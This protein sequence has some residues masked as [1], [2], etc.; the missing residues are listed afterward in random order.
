MLI[1]Y[2][3]CMGRRMRLVDIGWQDY[4]MGEPSDGF[5]FFSPPAMAR[6]IE[7]VGTLPA[8]GSLDK[9]GGRARL[10]SS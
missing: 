8:L 7:T 3:S 1:S 6:G 10:L 2:V 4:D 9:E 5:F